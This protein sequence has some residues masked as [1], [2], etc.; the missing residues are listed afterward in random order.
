MVV[1]MVVAALVVDRPLL[2]TG[3]VPVDD[4]VVVVT[5]MVAV[6]VHVAAAPVEV[7]AVILGGRHRRRE[8]QD[9]G[10]QGWNAGSHGSFPR[11]LMP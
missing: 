9:R 7:A 3:T 4:N 8:D 5:V 2:V 1:V 11:G 6:D 10:D